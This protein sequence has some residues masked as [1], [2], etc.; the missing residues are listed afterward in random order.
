[1][2]DA[3]LDLN[4]RFNGKKGRLR[5]R[6]CI[7]GGLFIEAKEGCQWWE[8]A[9]GWKLA[10]NHSEDLSVVMG[11]WQKLEEQGITDARRVCLIDPCLEVCHADEPPVDPKAWDFLVVTYIER[12][13]FCHDGVDNCEY[14]VDEERKPHPGVKEA[15]LRDQLKEL[16][17]VLSLI[18]L[19]SSC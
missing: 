19:S 17:G 14:V 9:S 7:V 13:P 2:S 4:P 16:F 1:M 10:D 15:K 8:R 11:L 18:Y 6:S 12:G 3:I 5:N